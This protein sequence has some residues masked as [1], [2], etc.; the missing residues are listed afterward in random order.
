MKT[1]SRRL[2]A[3]FSAIMLTALLTVTGTLAQSIQTDT[4]LALYINAGEDRSVY[5]QADTQGEAIHILA[6]GEVFEPIALYNDS[7]QILY[8]LPTG[9][10]VPGFTSPEGL[11]P[12]EPQDNA[13]MAILMLP[14]Q[15][16]RAAL[17]SSS[18][19]SARSLGKYYSGVLTQVTGA[20]QSEWT[21]VRIGNLEGYFE[22]RFLLRDVPGAALPEQLP[23]VSVA[24]RDAP[25]LALRAEQSFQSENLGNYSNGSFVTVLGVTEDFVHVVTPDGRVGFMM[26]WGVT[27]QIPFADAANTGYIPEPK[28]QEMVIHNTG[29]EGAHLRT[30]ASASSDSLGLYLNGTRVIRLGGGEYWAEVWVDGAT[31]WMMAK[32]LD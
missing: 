19:V 32:L 11:R 31:G 25:G 30:K 6:A 28:G 9:E 27:P 26:A 23:T 20:S 29:G 18:S 10:R 4:S 17:R 24:N 5:G 15:G 16:Q 21:P 8:Y 13:G 22:T 14:S 2:R 7:A 1:T 12:K 3:V